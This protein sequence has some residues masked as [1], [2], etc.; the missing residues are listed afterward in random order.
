MDGPRWTE[1]VDDLVDAG[2]VD[3]AIALLES[4]VSKL[5]TSAAAPSA[6]DLRLATA[7]GDLAGLHA[8][9]GNTLRAD[10]LRA[11]A[12]V[13]R[14]RAAAPGALGDQ[15]LP[16]KCISQEGAVGSK[17]SE[18]SANTEQNND[19]EED[20][21]EA[22]ADSGALDDTLVSSLDQEARVPSCSSSEKSSTPSGPKRRGRGSF[23][24]DKSVLYSDQCGS[25]RDLDDKESSP[26]S[27]SKGHVDEQENNA[28]AAARQFGT[29]HVLVLYDF[30]PSTR[31]TD[32]ERIFE[33]FGDHGVAIRWVNDTSALAVFRTPSAASEAQSCIP[34]RY[35]VRS[36]KEN[37]DLLTKIDGRDLEPPKPRPKTS[38]RTAQRLIAHGMGLKQFT[39]FGSDELKKQEEERKNRIAARQAMRDE[40]WGSD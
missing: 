23:L 2:N 24:Y 10:E 21:W 32:L 17:D 4:V 28:V 37:D 9:R 11:R 29:R 3:G 20:D 36:L 13:L 38:A 1:E 30:L 18:V 31:T 19:D 16:Q 25:E 6:A 22:I 26:H 7:L 40:A 35:K 27:G 34:P 5:S 8:S 39:N 15:E 14:S 33:K 12:I